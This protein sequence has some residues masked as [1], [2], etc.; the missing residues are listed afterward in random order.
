L[1]AICSDESAKTGLIAMINTVVETAVEHELGRA[2]GR[3]TSMIT[4]MRDA[5]SHSHKDIVSLTTQ[6]IVCICMLTEA[7]ASSRSAPAPTI[8][9]VNGK[10][11][12]VAKADWIS[13]RKAVRQ[14]WVSQMIAQE[15]A[16]EKLEMLS[17]DYRLDGE[18]LTEEEKSNIR[19]AQKDSES[20]VKHWRTNIYSPFHFDGAEVE[21]CSDEYVKF[22]VPESKIY[23]NT[24]RVATTSRTV[25]GSK[26]GCRL[27]RL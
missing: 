16:A 11:E 12:P 23:L 26:S 18:R 25:K 7:A 6:A 1:R 9:G 5:M 8:V 21:K 20:L 14:A 19:K 27:M 4:P 13:N 3:V 10:S 22:P 24:S 17:S 2:L 15:D